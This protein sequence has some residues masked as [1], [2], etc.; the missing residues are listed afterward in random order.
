MLNILSTYGLNKYDKIPEQLA[1][2]NG[3]DW[4]RLFNDLSDTYNSSVSIKPNRSTSR[5]I[6]T[7]AFPVLPSDHLSSI[8]TYLAFADRVFLDD[9]LAP[10][11][12]RLSYLNRKD[13]YRY[14]NVSLGKNALIKEATK[15][16]QFYLRAKELIRDKKL[17]LYS[18]KCNPMERPHILGSFIYPNE[19]IV[20][21]DKTLSRI[22]NGNENPTYILATLIIRAG[23]VNFFRHKEKI[24]IQRL[25]NSSRLTAFYEH[26]LTNANVVESLI[27]LVLRGG[28]PGS[29]TDL[30]RPE[31]TY[32]FRKIIEAAREANVNLPSSNRIPV[33][34]GFSN[35]ILQI[36]VLSNIPPERV[37]EIVSKNHLAFESFQYTLNQNILQLSASPGSRERESELL[38]I[39]EGIQRDCT[40]IQKEFLQIRNSLRNAFATNLSIASASIIVAGV[41]TIPS[42]LDILSITATVASSAS[43]IA[44][45]SQFANKWLEYR[46]KFGNL[47]LNDNF[48]I[49]KI[50]HDS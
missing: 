37:F 30:F 33:P 42:N 15:T 34:M 23:V 45:I 38:A 26:F 12:Y 19:P 46:E 48:F 27:D 13:S 9:A 17:I 44:S 31:F 20:R 35:N 43:L 41:S 16:I 11:A 2:F 50:T 5:S 1:S 4:L 47:S 40:H 25:T 21:E 24:D 28:L 3:D 7:F 29:S 39:K 10:I 22:L 32:L 8:T 6:L 49:W 18:S 14:L 36:P